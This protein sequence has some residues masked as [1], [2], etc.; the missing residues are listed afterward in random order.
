MV[1]ITL[2]EMSDETVQQLQSN[3]VRQPAFAHTQ[4]TTVAYTVTLDPAPTTL[5]EGFGITIVPHVTNADNPTLNINKL[6]AITLKDQCGNGYT[7][8]KLLPGQ[9]YTFRKVGPDLIVDSSGDNIPD[10]SLTTQGK[11]MLSNAVDS[12]NESQ[13]ATSKA[14][15]TAYDRANE[16]FQS[17]VSAKKGIVDAVNASG[18]NAST[19]DTW[20]GLSSKISK[21]NK[22]K[23]PLYKIGGNVNVMFPN[24]SGDAYHSADVSQG[25]IFS[26]RKNLTYKVELNGDF[27]I[28]ANTCF[29]SVAHLPFHIRYLSDT[30][31]EVYSIYSVYMQ[32][33]E[34]YLTKRIYEKQ[35]SSSDWNSR[36]EWIVK[37]SDSATVQDGFA[38]MYNKEAV[39]GYFNPNDGKWIIERR[40]ILN[41]SIIGSGIINIPTGL[42]YTSSD[43]LGIP[44][45]NGY[46]L[47]FY[48]NTSSPKVGSF[49]IVNYKGETKFEYINNAYE[50]D[51]IERIL[52]SSKRISTSYSVSGNIFSDA[53]ILKGANG[54]QLICFD[55][56]GGLYEYSL[57]IE[58]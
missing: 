18:G 2:Q 52:N 53:I 49:L 57:P 11:V 26:G 38:Q 25:Y 3:Y 42:P 10:A 41:G 14:V 27:S 48:S 34:S 40:S 30:M 54:K 21:I 24:I 28:V 47:L 44:L 16:A 20:D 12:N 46:F 43:Y 35:T 55:G 32:H 36:Q 50:S 1:G 29:G 22:I 31:Y 23:N 17:G 19:N 56:M 39:F 8:G 45:P 13:A 51:G 33:W 58:I 4:G 7:T 5:S 37:F 15:K 9:P 6:G